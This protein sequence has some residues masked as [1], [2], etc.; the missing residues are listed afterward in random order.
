MPTDQGLDEQAARAACLAARGRRPRLVA[1]SLHKGSR[2]LVK[3]RTRKR[4]D[5]A[6]N[7]Q[8]ARCAGWFR[9]PRSKEIF[10]RRLLA[11]GALILGLLAAH[12]CF[13][14]TPEIWFGAPL[15]HGRNAP[16]IADADKLFSDDPDWNRL[17]AEIQ[18][19]LFGPA[20]MLA[21][22][23]Q[24]HAVADN[25]RAHNIKLALAVNAIVIGPADHC[26][27]AEGYANPELTQ[28]IIARLKADNVAPDY[29]R[30]DNPVT[31]AT[32]AKT[33]PACRFPPEE[34]GSR[35]A[36]TV[37]LYHQAFPH[38][39]FGVTESILAPHLRGDADHPPWKTAFS[40][41]NASYLAHGGTAYPFQFFHCEINTARDPDWADTVRQV[42]SVVRNLG[43]K[44]G[45]QYTGTWRDLT[46]LGWTHDVENM[47]QQ[48]ENPRS[49]GGLVPD[50]AI[51]QS[52]KN[53]L[54]SHVFPQS[55][56]GTLSS[57]VGYYIALPWHR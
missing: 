25:L 23:R 39:V 30:I 36:A 31:F 7:H 42:M 46:D 5:P 34:L 28:K 45:M 17:A 22:G 57:V 37:G 54:P 38:A 21:M 43:M 55:Q 48:I 53:D 19:Y 44:T 56:D 10:I 27:P 47:M 20:V 52:W 16:A 50:Q 2:I 49:G 35:V 1:Y 9:L 51:I 6:A 33:M 8:Q 12:P 41:F 13:A 32:Y 14:T 15:F 4:P 29:F 26:P 3:K 24:F 18:V 11:S 40:Q